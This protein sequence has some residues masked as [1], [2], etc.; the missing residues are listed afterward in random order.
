[1]PSYKSHDDIKK[2]P[3]SRNRSYSD[4]EHKQVLNECESINEDHI[5]NKKYNP[6]NTDIDNN[7]H[8]H[9]VIT[10]VQSQKSK[11]PISLLNEWAMRGDGSCEKKQL[12]SYTL[13]AITGQAHR[14]IFT[15]M[16]RLNDKTGRYL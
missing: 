3:Y 9:H 7:V 8:E 14:P 10:T 12:V 5:Q 13:V 1:M 16:C 6:E 11:T 2:K 4:L 15:Y